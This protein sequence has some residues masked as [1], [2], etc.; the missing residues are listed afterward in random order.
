MDEAIDNYKDYRKS[1]DKR[2]P[3]DV[4][5]FDYDE[6]HSIAN[7]GYIIGYLESSKKG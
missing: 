3:E 4:K 2:N 6:M 1:M 7:I 5:G